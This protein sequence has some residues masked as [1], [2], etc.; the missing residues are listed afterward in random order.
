MPRDDH[1][2]A[3]RPSWPRRTALLAV[4]AAGLTGAA[5]CGTTPTPD[6]PPASSSAG[7]TGTPT[8]TRSTPPSS[9]PSTSTTTPPRAS[10]RA[11]TPPTSRSSARS[12]PSRTTRP[13][14]TTP[15]GTS[16]SAPPP[17]ARTSTAP[18]VSAGPGPL[19]ATAVGTWWHPAPD[20]FSAANLWRFDPVSEALPVG[21]RTGYQ[22]TGTITPFGT[23]FA[24]VYARSGDDLELSFPT[25]TRQRLTLLRYDRARDVL[26]V[27]YEGYVQVW[28]GCR[29]G[30]MPA[31]ALAACR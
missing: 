28:V 3:A 12:S 10:T 21:T 17:P 14:S 30:L 19:G 24:F 22:P 9:S 29:S 27:R 6:P 5:A 2:P 15:P 1:R 23:Q 20:Q 18:Q 11:A 26:T 8:P 4:L 25:G 16:R 7:V 13:G 31:V